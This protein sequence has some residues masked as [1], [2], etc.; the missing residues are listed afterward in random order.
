MSC[1][2]ALYT[3]KLGF[4]LDKQVILSASMVSSVSVLG[5]ADKQAIS[6]LLARFR[7]C[8][9]ENTSIPVRFAMFFPARSREVTLA[10]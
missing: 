5:K 1:P 8:N 10:A 3:F 9:P 7:D 6:G 2:V 4:E